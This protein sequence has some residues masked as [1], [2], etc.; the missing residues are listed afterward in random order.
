MILW[1]KP[2]QPIGSYV[3]IYVAS[4]IINVSSYICTKLATWGNTIH[5]IIT[6]KEVTMK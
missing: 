6:L 4:V 5:N 1:D 2:N 3:A